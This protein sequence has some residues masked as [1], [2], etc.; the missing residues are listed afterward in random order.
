M[1][2]II[3]TNITGLMAPWML[4]VEA[5]DIHC[6]STESSA[7]SL[8]DSIAGRDRLVQVHLVL[9][10]H[11]LEEQREMARELIR[12]GVYVSLYDPATGGTALDPAI[13]G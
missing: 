2:T 9:A 4:H 3:V 10:A 1:R 8:A 11:S 12:Y 5:G 6:C 13:K 7:K